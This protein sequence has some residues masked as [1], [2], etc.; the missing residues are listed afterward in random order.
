MKK[1][2]T[3][4]ILMAVLLIGSSCQ[5]QAEPPTSTPVPTGTNSSSG[6]SPSPRPIYV[7]PS[8]K[9]EAIKIGQVL[10]EI[11]TTDIKGMPLTLAARGQEKG[12]VIVIYAPGCDVCHANMPRWI[13]LFN[14]FFTPR[15]IPFTALS[16]QSPVETTRSIEEMKIPFRVVVMP[17]VDLRFG[18]NIPDVPT[19]IALD[20]DGQIK[21]V[22]V[23]KLDSAQLA[24]VIKVYCP[25]CNVNVEV[26]KPS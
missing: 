12:E 14:Q 21:G 1:Y 18:Y 15:Q 20:R 10:P 26:K 13:T 22:W 2:L 7:P 16:V 17:D 4:T 6:N 25:E 8:P 19:T 5:P 9:Q 3:V 11:S 24:E 23:G